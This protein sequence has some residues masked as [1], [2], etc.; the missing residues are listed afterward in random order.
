MNA[1][2]VALG[3][4]TCFW[5]GYT[6]YSDYLA[7]E[8]FQTEDPDFVTPAHS[9]ADGVDFVATPEPVLWGHH[10]TSVAGLAPLVGPAVA[11]IWGWVPA[12]LWVVLGS[13]FLGAVH[14]YGALALSARN[15]GTSIADLAGGVIG[16]RARVLFLSL[17]FFLTWIVVAVFAYVIAILFMKFPASVLPV[18]FQIVVAVL[19]GW[20]VHRGK[21]SLLGPCLLALVVLYGLVWVG[22]W[23][24]LE[25]PALFPDNP[26][27]ALHEGQLYT[28][29]AFLLVYAFGAS[30]MPV[31]LLLQPRDFIN[32]HQLVVG[33]GGLYLSLFLFHPP[34][35][36]PAFVTHPTGASPLFPFLF[37]TIA[38]GAISGFH[39]LVGSGTTAKQLDRL[40]SA[41]WIG[42]GGMIGEG[43]VALLATLACTA[44]FPTTEAWHAH[45]GSW[46]AA[47]GLMAKL[48]A[49]VQGGAYFFQNGLGIPPALGEAVVAVLIISFGATTLDSATRIQRYI[50]QELGGSLGIRPLTNPWVAAGIAA[51]FPVALLIG[52]NWKHLW[53][54]FGASNQ[55]LAAMSLV[56]LS[57]WLIQKKRPYLPLFLPMLFVS[58]ITLVALGFQVLEHWRSGNMLLFGLTLTMSCLGLWTLMEGYQ[59]KRKAEKGE[60]PPEQLR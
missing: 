2:L 44:G 14:D 56:V 26:V 11:V 22:T 37:V 3:G 25:I 42:Y 20:W 47:S 32:S 52:D 55:L 16:E 48:G 35:V 12:V 6:F 45:Y 54:L 27:T 29:I 1:A 4:L 36:A 41:R 46:Q 33:L 59:A 10:F 24:P 40:P 31:W 60:A 17:V 51:F 19:I 7:R 13:I 57:V 38:C 5:L 49:L 28:W 53:P 15:G 34:V 9:Q 8:V 50:I 58:T 39:G 23:M 43:S 18:N 30:L 21:G